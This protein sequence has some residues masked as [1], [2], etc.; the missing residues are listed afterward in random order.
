MDEIIYLTNLCSTAIKYAGGGLAVG[1]VLLVGES[2]SMCGILV[3][4]G[5]SEELKGCH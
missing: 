1:T 5:S 3:L 4:Y 2:D